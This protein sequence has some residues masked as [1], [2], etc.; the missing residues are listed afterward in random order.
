MIW[1]TNFTIDASAPISFTSIFEIEAKSV[2]T[3]YRP[4]SIIFSIASAPT[5]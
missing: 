5:P 3:A 1:F 2:S 4:S